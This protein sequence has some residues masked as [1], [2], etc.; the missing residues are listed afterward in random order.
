M[1]KRV[2]AKVAPQEPRDIGLRQSEQAR[3]L[4]PGDA[5]LTDDGV[6]AADELC[7]QQVHFSVGKAKGPRRRC[8]CVRRL[9][10]MWS[11]S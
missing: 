1:L 6:D 3:G 4:G 8:C 2:L 10:R 11:W 7:L 9:G 5:T